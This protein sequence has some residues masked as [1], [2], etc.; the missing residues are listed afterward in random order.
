MSILT[1]FGL[2]SAICPMIFGPSSSST[3]VTGYDPPAFSCSA[4]SGG[5][6]PAPRRVNVWTLPRP[7]SWISSKSDEPLQYLQTPFGGEFTL[8]HF[9]HVCPTRRYRCGI[10]R[11]YIGTET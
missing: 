6:P 3:I 5:A 4:N 10:V 8:P 9:L 2:T 1:S 7:L 11:Q